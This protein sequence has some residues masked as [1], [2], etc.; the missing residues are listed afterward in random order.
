MKAITTRVVALVFVLGAIAGSAQASPVTFTGT[1]TNDSDVVL[2]EISGSS[3][4]FT[5][6]TSGYAQGGF[7]PL[8]FLFDPLN[9][10]WPTYTGNGQIADQSLTFGVD[11]TFLLTLSVAD[12]EPNQNLANIVWYQ[13]DPKFTDT[14]YGCTEGQFCTRD[15]QSR[16][17][18][19]AITFSGDTGVTFSEVG[20]LS[21]VPSPSSF[22]LFAT[23]L[24]LLGL[25]AR[26][27][28]IRSVLFCL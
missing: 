27:R 6:T 11:R 14:M 16:S 9:G 19:W 21:A 28:W 17:G 26:R 7:N 15:H 3:G 8:M 1:F 23:G 18:A 5:A 2:F 12:N 24:G 10:W 25:M 22:W 4:S 20:A 13:T